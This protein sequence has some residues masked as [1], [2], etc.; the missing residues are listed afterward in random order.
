MAPLVSRLRFATVEPPLL[1]IQALKGYEVTL[2]GETSVPRAELANLLFA[3]GA[4]VRVS[5]DAGVAAVEVHRV[6]D[7]K[8]IAARTHGQDGAP[9][10]QGPGPVRRAVAP[11][12]LM[13]RPALC[14]PLVRTGLP[15]PAQGARLNRP[16][17][18]RGAHGG[19]GWG[20]AR[21]AL[22]SAAKATS[23]THAPHARTHEE[24]R[25]RAQHIH[26]HHHHHHH[27]F[28]G[29]PPRGL[30]QTQTQPSSHPQA[31]PHPGG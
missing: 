31:Y 26:H 28:I 29:D 21:L 15:R 7:R 9:L 5:R 24:M 20:R 11:R 27:H 6:C 14:P 3:A 13:A 19:G 25:A 4:A 22:C 12:L 16:T 17:G 30:T 10:G 18:A 2:R 1:A 23:P 8:R